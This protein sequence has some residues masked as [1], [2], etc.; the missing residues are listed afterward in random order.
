[1]ETLIA[2]EAALITLFIALIMALPKDGQIA[3]CKIFTLI[4]TIAMGAVIIGIAV[5][6]ADGNSNSDHDQPP[7]PPLNKGTITT[8]TSVMS[9]TWSN[10]TAGIF[11]T[12]GDEVCMEGGNIFFILLL[13]S[14]HH[15]ES[16]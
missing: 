2:W 9:A 11:G 5:Q 12:S 14:D 10:E 6:I 1:M 4:S 13:L 3:V 8:A 16:H 7:D 15:C